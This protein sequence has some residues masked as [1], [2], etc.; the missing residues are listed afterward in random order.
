MREG[1]GK[2]V[3]KQKRRKGECGVTVWILTAVRT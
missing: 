1:A 2:E 3:S